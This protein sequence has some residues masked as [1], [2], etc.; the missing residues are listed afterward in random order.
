MEDPSNFDV[1][2]T[3]TTTTRRSFASTA[4]NDAVTWSIIRAALRRAIASRAIE[5]VVFLWPDCL[6]PS[7]GYCEALTSSLPKH[8][9]VEHLSSVDER[10]RELP[11]VLPDSAC[12]VIVD[13][14]RLSATDL[15]T[16]R[17]WAA[18]KPDARMLVTRTL[19]VAAH[20]NQIEL[21]NGPL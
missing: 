12:I 13:D 19:N 2:A 16:F 18:A 8:V 3:T 11:M 7:D 14:F 4:T 9:L 10:G 17:R 20:Y 6:P 21:R 15:A 5:R 1:V